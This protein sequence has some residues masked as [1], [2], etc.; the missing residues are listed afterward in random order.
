M[1]PRWQH[2]LFLTSL[3]FIIT[4]KYLRTRC[5]WENPRTREG[6][7]LRHPTFTTQRLRQIVLEGKRSRHIFTTLP[8]PQA[9]AGPWI[10][11]FPEP[12]VPPMGKKDPRRDKQFPQCCGSLCRSHYSHPTP[13]GL[14]GNL[15]ATTTRNLTM[16]E[17]QR[18]ACNNQHMNLGRLSFY[19]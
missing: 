2:R 4:T 10:E 18:G 14:Q 3:P 8:L 11:V 17:M 13:Q 5:H 7:S 15:Q 9:S 19:L 6:M 1:S 12:S 16:T